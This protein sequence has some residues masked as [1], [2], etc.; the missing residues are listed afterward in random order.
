MYQLQ[1]QRFSVSYVSPSAVSIYQSHKYESFKAK[2][3]VLTL[4]HC[5]ITCCGTGNVVECD[6]EYK[7]GD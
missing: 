1:Q 2:C 6:S 4:Y 5:I 7:F 3:S